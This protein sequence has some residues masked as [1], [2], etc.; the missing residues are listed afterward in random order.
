M[1]FYFIGGV[2]GGGGGVGVQKTVSI[3][4]DHH[5]PHRSATHLLRIELIRFLIVACGMLVHSSSMAVRS[6][7]ILTGTG[8]LCRICRSRVSQTCSMGDM[9]SE[10]AGHARTGMF[11]QL[12]NSLPPTLDIADVCSQVRRCPWQRLKKRTRAICPYQAPARRLVNP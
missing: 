5:L 1:Q 3:W 9:S 7:W 11:Y 2:R 8:T 12:C 6:C 4:C 10:Y